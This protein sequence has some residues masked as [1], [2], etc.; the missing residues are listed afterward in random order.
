MSS[1]NVT[2]AVTAAPSSAVSD[3]HDEPWTR[4]EYHER[5]ASAD[6]IERGVNWIK[7]DYTVTYIED[8]T[9]GAT[10]EQIEEFIDAELHILANTKKMRYSDLKDRYITAYLF[11][12][13]WRDKFPTQS[14]SA[15][16]A[17][18]RRELPLSDALNWLRQA[19]ADDW[20]VTRLC[21]EI[22]GKPTP[23]KT[24]RQTFNI[25]DL[26]PKETLEYALDLILEPSACEVALPLLNLPG[27]R[28]ELAAIWEAASER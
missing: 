19:N 8:H 1:V 14:W 28:F 7:G 15:F 25:S 24:E 3:A 16:R 20:G 10:P 22:D 23:P 11:P 27:V 26:C 4:D 21:N 9:K 13:E 18:A 17:C 2:S 5:M 12:P 6:D